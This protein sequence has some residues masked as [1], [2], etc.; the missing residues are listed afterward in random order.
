MKVKLIKM[1]FSFNMENNIVWNMV[2]YTISCSGFGPQGG[3]IWKW[4][5]VAGHYI[6]NMPS[7]GK[8]I[9]AFIPCFRIFDHTM[10]PEMALFKLNQLQVK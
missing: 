5:L 8:C 1:Q 4:N 3:I 10:N 7:E 9:S 6:L 2:S